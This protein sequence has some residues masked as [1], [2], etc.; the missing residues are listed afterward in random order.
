MVGLPPCKEDGSH[1]LGVQWCN[2]GCIIQQ[3]AAHSTPQ[4][5]FHPSAMKLYNVLKSASPS[6][7]DSSTLTLLKDI[8][9]ACATCQ[10][11]APKPVSFQVTVPG[12][13]I[14]NDGLALDLMWIGGKAVL[15]VI[16]INTQFSS[17]IFLRCQNVTDVWNSFV[18]CW[19][20]LWKQL[21]QAS[22]IELKLRGVESHNSLAS[23]E[24]YHAPLR[25]IY[26]KIKDSLPNTT[27]EIMLRYAVKDM[28]G[29]VR[30]EGLVPSLLVFGCMPRL[31]GDT[32]SK[33]SGQ[34]S[35]MHTLVVARKEIETIIADLRVSHAFCSQIPQAASTFVHI[36]Q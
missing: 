18:E 6:K 20:S 14:F 35:R 25:R 21:V 26:F 2:F 12:D 15:H 4:A 16:D 32:G 5:L 33:L 17:A 22:E 29:T 19:N 8:A 3:A 1:V 30:P 10:R 24:R 31:P 9:R 23:G 11:L 13:V 34:G 28:N 36:R 27:P 7:T